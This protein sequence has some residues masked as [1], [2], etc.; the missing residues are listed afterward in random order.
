MNDETKDIDDK[1]KSAD[2]SRGDRLRRNTSSDP[3]SKTHEDEHN[4]MHPDSWSG[5]SIVEDAKEIARGEKPREQAGGG[6]NSP[7]PERPAT[8]SEVTRPWS[9]EPTEAGTTG[10]TAGVDYSGRPRGENDEIEGEP[11]PARQA[12]PTI[13][14]ASDDSE[15]RPE[16]TK[17]A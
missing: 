1:D 13:T 5:G 7:G 16:V 14:P 12:P 11:G 15:D 2:E 9:P 6:P 3:D 4:P 10:S 17:R 8:P